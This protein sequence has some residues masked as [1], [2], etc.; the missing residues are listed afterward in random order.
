MEKLFALIKLIGINPNGIFSVNVWVNPTKSWINHET[1]VLPGPSFVGSPL[2]YLPV[3]KKK[4]HGFIHIYGLMFVCVRD[5]CRKEW[6][7]QRQTV[8]LEGVS[9]SDQSLAH[10]CVNV[11]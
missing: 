2:G 3:Q 10:R 11:G 1:G 7:R 6:W 9:S 4:C 8:C 5:V